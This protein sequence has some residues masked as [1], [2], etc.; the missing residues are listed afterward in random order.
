MNFD[1]PINLIGSNISAPWP[2]P[3]MESFLTLLNLGFTIAIGVFVCLILLI[4]TKQKVNFP[5]FRFFLTWAI[6]ML[7]LKP[8]GGFAWGVANSG[9]ITGISVWETALFTCSISGLF[10]Y[11]LLTI[12]KTLKSKNSKAHA[13]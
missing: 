4:I 7:A 11:T 9:V 10:T 6:I 13:D 3:T 2:F 8:Y 1:L 5:A 12:G